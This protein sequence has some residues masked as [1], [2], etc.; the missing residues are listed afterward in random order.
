[1][2]NFISERSSIKVISFMNLN[3]QLQQLAEKYYVL[4]SIE[5]PSDDELHQLEKILE[6][7]TIDEEVSNLLLVVDEF[8]AIEAG[9]ISK[10]QVLYKFALSTLIIKKITFHT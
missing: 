4:M 10:E 8:I 5:E 3:Q 1:M 2:N 7:A 6:L 9:L